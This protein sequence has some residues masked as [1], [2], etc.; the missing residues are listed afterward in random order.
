MKRKRTSK[1]I[2][3]FKVTLLPVLIHFLLFIIGKTTKFHILGEDKYKDLQR[4]G[5]S[6]IFAFWHNRI[7]LLP[8]YYRY[9]LKRK[10]ICF[11]ASPSTDGEILS[12]LMKRLE[13]RAVRGSTR[14]YGKK[15]MQEM[16]QSLKTGYDG[17][18]VP[19][20]PQGP[21]YKVQPGI[22]HIAKE[23][24]LPIVPAAYNTRNKRVLPTWD[25]FLL[26]L[27]FSQAV[28]IY[29]KPLWIEKDSH[30]EEGMRKLEEGLNEVTK[31]A[32]EYF[33]S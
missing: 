4:E 23:T 5:K 27:P 30:R 32:D 8:F 9:K 17:A 14:H 26:P 19:D 28:I 31:E 6:V 21:K 16:V 11:L 33:D 7:F 12:R 20:G 22:I 1:A 2:K 29:G 3:N 13:F 25:N 18:I 15:S 10:N 24:G